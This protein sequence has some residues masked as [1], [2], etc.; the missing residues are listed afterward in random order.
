MVA[1]VACFLHAFSRNQSTKR[2]RKRKKREKRETGNR[3]QKEEKGRKRSVVSGGFPSLDS[4]DP[5]ICLPQ[6][7]LLKTVMKKQLPFSFSQR[8]LHN[9]TWVFQT[10]I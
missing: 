2:K 6:I 5:T 1:R 10:V 4:V 9:K 8:R 3:G 7:A